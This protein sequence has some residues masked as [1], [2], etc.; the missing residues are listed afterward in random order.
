M[1]ASL[2]ALL[3]ESDDDDWQ[4]SAVQLHMACASSS[5]GVL[6]G[7]LGERPDAFAASHGQQ[8]LEEGLL[9]AC[10]HGSVD[11]AAVLLR[12]GAA[13]TA[14]T[15][16]GTALHMACQANSEAC[17]KLLLD[18]RA[19]PNVTSAE[20]AGATPLFVA[21]FNGHEG[22]LRA[23]LEARADPDIAYEG[24]TSPLQ[25]TPHVMTQAEW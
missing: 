12:Y 10:H 7:L 9:I 21:A 5:A 6:E 13:A 22:C 4:P 20:C 1:A 24:G 3:D 23:L 11:C 18:A 2:D 19:E 25:S 14:C 16:S 8:L 15:G 17:T